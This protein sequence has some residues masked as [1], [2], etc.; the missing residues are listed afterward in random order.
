MAGTFIFFSKASQGIF[1]LRICN[2]SFDWSSC[3]PLE[4]FKV[5]LKALA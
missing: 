4:I 3:F 2:F 5:M 1:V